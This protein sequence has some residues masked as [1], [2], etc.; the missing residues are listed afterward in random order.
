MDK[1]LTH[2]IVEIFLLYIAAAIKTQPK[3]IIIIPTA[4]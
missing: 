3:E 4:K 2:I 1:E